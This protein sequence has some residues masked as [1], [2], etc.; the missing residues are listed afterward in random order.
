MFLL[1]V[2]L[3]ATI[4]FAVFF[5]LPDDPK[6]TFLVPQATPRDINEVIEKDLRLNDPIYIQYGNFLFKMFTGKFFISAARYKGE[7]VGSHIYAP[8]A[9]TLVVFAVVVFFSMMIGWIAGHFISSKRRSGPRRFV[10]ISL[11]LLF[12]I[13]AGA[14]A[15]LTVPLLRRLGYGSPLLPVLTVLGAILLTF[16]IGALTVKRAHPGASR[17]G[18]SSLSSSFSLCSLLETTSS[19][20]GIVPKSQLLIG[21]TMVCVLILDLSFWY[22]GL[23]ALMWAAI[24]MRDR[25]LLVACV[26]VIAMIVAVANFL[27]DLFVVFAKHN[28]S[29]RRLPADVTLETE[30]SSAAT[31]GGESL[32]TGPSLSF[33]SIWREYYRGSRIG[34]MALILLC[35]I[36]VAAI[37][38]PVISTVPNPGSSSSLE[39]STYPNG[40]PNPF[41]PS[42]RESPTSGFVHPLGTDNSG[43]DVYS[44]LVYGSRSFVIDCLIIVLLCVAASIATWLL[45]MAVVRTDSVLAKIGAIVATIFADA[46]LSLPFFVI[47]A[48]VICTGISRT[49][50]SKTW[51]FILLI[52]W[53][54]SVKVAIERLYRPNEAVRK[55]LHR[56]QEDREDRARI[57]PVVPEMLTWTLHVTK[58]VA[59]VGLLSIYALDFFQLGNPSEIS[60][61][62][63]LENAYVRNAAGTG[64]W[65][66][67][68]PA[69]I[70]TMF[71]IAALYIALDTLEYAFRKHTQ[72]SDL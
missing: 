7:P 30:D 44:M 22:K 12:S 49:V 17:P 32:M 18:S 9:A 11:T 67:Y 46:L 47:F 6:D 42:F 52:G 51:I 65:W 69:L 56:G 33:G 57:K 40:R 55:T 71:A 27:F 58:F 64:A 19:I 37:V 5:V 45:A 70:C 63:M 68:V 10:E 62:M 60:W 16:G 53:A 31:K 48:A 4:I 41:P 15:M 23:G 28:A 72:D 2:W 24:N 20:S 59:V 21:W 43:R 50:I 36:V 39:P 8:L 35:A 26:F 13:P 25:Q 38:A 3:V 54:P 1:S 61:G 14:L 34:I 66:T 29:Q